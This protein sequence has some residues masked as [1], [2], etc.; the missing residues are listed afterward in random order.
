[1]PSS[2]GKMHQRK[3]TQYSLFDI[4]CRAAKLPDY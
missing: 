1:M 2:F 4:H 3:G